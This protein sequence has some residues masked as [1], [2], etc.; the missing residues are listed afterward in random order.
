MA[1]VVSIHA[2]KSNLFRLVKRAAEGEEVL[3]DRNE[4]RGDAY[5]GSQPPLTAGRF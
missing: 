5:S 2:A 1:T 3:I 4:T